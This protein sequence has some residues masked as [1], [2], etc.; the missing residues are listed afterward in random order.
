M[1]WWWNSSLSCLSISY[2]YMVHNSSLLTWNVTQEIGKK[3]KTKILCC[4]NC[5]KLLVINILWISKYSWSRLPPPPGSF[6]ETHTIRS[7]KPTQLYVF[8]YEW[9]RH[10]NG[11]GGGGFQCY[12]S[13]D[14]QWDINSIPLQR[15][16]ALD[17]FCSNNQSIFSLNVIVYLYYVIL[18]WHSNLYSGNIFF[19]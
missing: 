15:F 17:S 7:N 4:K 13:R 12:I 10:T 5:N 11:E 16:L 9:N 3:T 2:M 8:L 18:E 1:P 19:A 6:Q 14:Q